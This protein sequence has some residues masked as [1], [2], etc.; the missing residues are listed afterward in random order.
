MRVSCK[1]QT[2]YL[3]TQARTHIFYIIIIN[4]FCVCAGLHAKRV[5]EDKRGTMMMNDVFVCVLCEA[6]RN[7]RVFYFACYTYTRLNT[8][9]KSRTLFSYIS[10]IA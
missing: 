6:R 8:T 9:Y 3:K 10:L 5:S 4:I 2:I 1:F 7:E